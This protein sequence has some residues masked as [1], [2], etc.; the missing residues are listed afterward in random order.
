MDYC[1]FIK[2][3]VIY[4]DVLLSRDEF[5]V[6]KDDGF[7]ARISVCEYGFFE[8]SDSGNRFVPV[9]YVLY[10]LSRMMLSEMDEYSSYSNLFNDCAFIKDTKYIMTGDYL[11]FDSYTFIS[12][13]YRNYK[14]GVIDMYLS[15]DALALFRRVSKKEMYRVD[16]YALVEDYLLSFSH[17]LYGKRSTVDITD[18][19]CV[20]NVAF[21]DVIFNY[22]LK[23]LNRECHS[24]LTTTD[25]MRR[26]IR[27]LIKK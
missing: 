15:L 27:T 17:K 11:V 24:E 23:K 12:N 22:E 5:F 19:F 26:H 14:N 10:N 25:I 2:N 13:A 16:A 3:I 21:S 1:S 20:V 4:L 6:L 7:S 18:C 9:S 8:E